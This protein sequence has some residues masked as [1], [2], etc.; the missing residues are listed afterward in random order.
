[1][2][3][4]VMIASSAYRMRLY[5]QVY[6]LTFLRFLPYGFYFFSLFYGRKYH[7]HL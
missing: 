2:T 3:I 4:F 6:H 5:S 1:M 7:F